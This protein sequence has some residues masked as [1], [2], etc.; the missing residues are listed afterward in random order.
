MEH[1]GEEKDG[2]GAGVARG[3]LGGDDFALVLQQSQKRR[4]LRGFYRISICRGGSTVR[5]LIRRFQ[6]VFLY[7]QVVRLAAA[8]VCRKQ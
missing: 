2:R 4:S 8:L 5:E 6:P 1:L 7:M 3:A